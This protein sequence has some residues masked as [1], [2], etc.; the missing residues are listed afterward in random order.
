M[1]PFAWQSRFSKTL[2]GEAAVNPRNLFA[3]LK[4]RNAK[5]VTKGD[6]Q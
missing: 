5:P 3:E 1:G 6:G 2:R 4:P